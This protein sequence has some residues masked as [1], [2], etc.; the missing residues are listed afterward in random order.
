VACW[1]A[2]PLGSRLARRH[3]PARLL[4]I[5]L[6]VTAAGF[7]ILWPSTAPA[8]ALIGLSLL[9]IGLGNL[10]PIGVALAVALAPGSSAL[11]SA[12]VVAVS[13]FAVVLAP[14]T[15]GTLADATSLTYALGVVPVMITLAAAGLAV[16][17]RRRARTAAA[18]PP[19]DA[20]SPSSSASREDATRRVDWLR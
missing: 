18:A 8:P 4:A 20:T 2:A 17:G 9:G 16:L 7:A 19:P 13:S 3:G 6:G 12:R 11:A 10:F 1:S 5:A 15:V 14:L